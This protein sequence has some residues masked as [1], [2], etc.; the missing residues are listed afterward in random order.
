[1]YQSPVCVR[2]VWNALSAL[3]LSPIAAGFPGLVCYLVFQLL[4]DTVSASLGLSPSLSSILSDA[5]SWLV[6]G[7]VS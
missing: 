1:M 4:A 6:S 3:G 2:L 5:V 7:L